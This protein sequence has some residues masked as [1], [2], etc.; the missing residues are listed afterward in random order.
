MDED[1]ETENILLAKLAEADFEIAALNMANEN[2]RKDYQR[3]HGEHCLDCCCAQS[4]K[5]LGITE[6]TGKSIPEH[7]AALR[8]R[9]DRLESERKEFVGQ[10]AIMWKAVRAV[11]DLIEQSQ[12]V[13]GLHLNGDGAP[14]N[15]LRTGGQF[16]QWLIEFDDALEVPRG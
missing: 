9:C 15:S 13:Y 11:Q 14:W 10:I 4:W 16:E 6:N 3:L 1:R 8:A 7:I 2:L 12:G 5:A